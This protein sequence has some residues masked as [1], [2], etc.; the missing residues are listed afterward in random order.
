MGNRRKEIRLQLVEF[1]QTQVCFLKFGGS[2]LH[3][4]ELDLPDVQTGLLPDLTPQ[5]GFGFF[6]VP[7]PAGIRE[8]V[9]EAVLRYRRGLAVAPGHAALWSNLGNVLKDLGRL[10]EAA[11]SYQRALE[12]KPDFAQVYNNRGNL[13][14]AQKKAARAIDDYTAAIKINPEY[15]AAIYNRAIAYGELGVYDK[16]L[17]DYT[18]A[19]E[20][21]PVYYE[22]L[23]NRGI[24]YARMML[25]TE[26][27]NDFTRAVSI[28]PDFGEAYQNR[29]FAY[30]FSGDTAKCAGDVRLLLERKYPVNPV[31][32]KIL[33]DKKMI[34]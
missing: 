24:I 16:A 19:I 34:Q 15:I 8:S 3:H 25:R 5:G 28:N 30:Y 4:H 2:F 27:I 33:R 1:L 26:A 6:T 11:A 18:L 13:L 9:A 10:D 7:D 17:A 12:L 31:L 32:L 22:A 21:K 23:N 14:M 20:K 29:A